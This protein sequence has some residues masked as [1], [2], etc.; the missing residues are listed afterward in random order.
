MAQTVGDL[1]GDG[2][3]ERRPDPGDGRRALVEPDR[4]RAGRA[5][6][7]P[8]APRG[9]AGQGDRRPARR[10][11]GHRRAGD[12]PAPPARRR[13]GLSTAG[14]WAP[15][16][17]YRARAAAQRPLEPKPPSPR[18][19]SVRAAASTGSARAIGAISELGDAVAGRDPEGLGR[20]VVEQQHPQFAAVAG[21]D[22]AGAVDQRDP[23]VASQA[24]A[25]QDQAGVPVGDLDRDPGADAPALAR[26]DVGR[27]A[28]VE[29]EPGVARVGAGRQ[30]SRP[31]SA[32]RL[33]A[34][35]RDPSAPCQSTTARLVE[36][37]Q[38]GDRH[39][40]VDEDAVLALGP[41]EVAGDLVQLV[42]A[43]ALGVGDQQ[44]DLGQRLLEG[45]LDPLAQLVEALAVDGRD[46]DGIAV[47]EL[48][49]APLAP[50]RA[51]RPC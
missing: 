45:R 14:T 6:G 39:P 29:V 43:P 12:R 20:V 23:V 15:G 27:L 7:R 13:R 4:G 37:V 47:A 32:W 42:Q 50:R 25:R 40:G 21:V 24:R 8:P 26:P 16:S 44:L 38:L 1:E 36:A 22:Q 30:Q 35:R 10:G 51:G 48:D 31:R 33:E 3:V 9:L 17:E 19:E 2:F 28:G 11:S 49:L 46:E 18:A 41:L 5:R 34:P